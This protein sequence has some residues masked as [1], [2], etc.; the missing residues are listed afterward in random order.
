MKKKILFSIAAIALFTV[1]IAFNSQ[2]NETEDLT[3]KNIEAIAGAGVA[4]G[5]H[6]D[7]GSWARC[8]YACIA[9]VEGTCILCGTNCQ[10]WDNYQP[11]AT[12][13]FCAIP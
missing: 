7:V 4:E 12:S 13:W 11:C 1:A 5:L 6:P 2:R 8:S 10:A 3:V 9:N